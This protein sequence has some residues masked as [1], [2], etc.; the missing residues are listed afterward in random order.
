M[1]HTPPLE[2]LRWPLH[3]GA[4]WRQAGTVHRL[5]DEATVDLTGECKVEA[6]ETITVPAGTFRT[7]KT[8]CHNNMGQ[9]FEQWFAPEVRNLVRTRRS[10]RD[11]LETRELAE[12]SL[13]P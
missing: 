11:G 8:T 13:A 5:K 10:R 4:A 1:R 3:V 9:I 2:F 7:L 12:Y 6:A